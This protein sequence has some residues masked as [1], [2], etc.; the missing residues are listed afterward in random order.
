MKALIFIILLF[1]I[2][3]LSQT[4][5]DSIKNIDFGLQ[6]N[7]YVEDCKKP[8]FKD[9]TVWIV[10]TKTSKRYP[11]QFYIKKYRQP[12]WVDFWERYLIE[13]KIIKK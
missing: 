6:W 4:K 10:D 12:S 8:Y 1:P 5:C 2:I 9:T 3:A 11:E 13:Q 7:K